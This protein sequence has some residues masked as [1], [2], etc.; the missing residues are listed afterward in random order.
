MWLFTL[1]SIQPWLRESYSF[2]W[3]G[4]WLHSLQI[5]L[6][7]E[8]YQSYSLHVADITD[9]FMTGIGTGIWVSK[10]IN[11]NHLCP[12]LNRGLITS[13]LK[14]KGIDY[15]LHH[16]E[17]YGC[18]YSSIPKS[19]WNHVS[20]GG[21]RQKPLRSQPQLHILSPSREGFTSNAKKIF[22]SRH[23]RLS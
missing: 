6:H 19:Q 20:K 10:Q 4:N 23:C 11:V 9:G 14:L 2:M 16:I 15:W 21:H 13:S 1:S 5:G 17:T 18:H 8:L 12:N 7:R 22:Q 3:P